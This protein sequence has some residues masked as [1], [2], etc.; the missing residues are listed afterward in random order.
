SMFLISAL[1]SRGATVYATTTSRG[2]DAALER[3]GVSVLFHVDA[4][5]A[6]FA[7]HRELRAV[8][9]AIGGFDRVCDPFFDLHIER[10]LPIMASGGRYVTCGCHEQFAAA[11]RTAARL[12]AVRVLQIAL[13]R[14]L[15][16][17]GNCLGRT[18]HLVSAL[19]DRTAGALR[20]PIDSVFGG[21]EVA[22]FLERTYLA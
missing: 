16:I 2:F 7:E 13:L 21:D 1:R 22:P 6:S 11:S 14:N 3:L 10:V 9:D 20:I 15:S 8:V 17:I 12:D 5:D 19:G 18:E 4:G